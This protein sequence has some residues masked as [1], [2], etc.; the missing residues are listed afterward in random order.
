MQ[1]S[2]PVDY[3][4]A[5]VIRLLIVGWMRKTWLRLDDDEVLVQDYWQAVSLQ[6]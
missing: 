4:E 5:E 2:L 1:A 3:G 6:L